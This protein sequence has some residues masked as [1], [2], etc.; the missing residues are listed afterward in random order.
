M[1]DDFTLQGTDSAHLFAMEYSGK[2]FIRGSMQDGPRDTV[3]LSIRR[4]SYRYPATATV[5][6]HFTRSSHDSRREPSSWGAPMENAIALHSAEPRRCLENT[7]IAT[8]S[9]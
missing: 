9:Y 2:A 6:P 5:T 3:L 1:N 4:T 7:S 8:K